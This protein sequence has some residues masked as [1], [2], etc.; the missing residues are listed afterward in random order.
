[1]E[2]MDWS[3]LRHFLAVARAG[4]TNKAARELGVNHTTC[5]RRIAALESAL[6]LPLFEHGRDGYRLTERGSELLPYAERVEAEVRAFCDAA[7]AGARRI[8]GTIRVTTNSS[9]ADAILVP[10]VRDL[11]RTVPDVRIDIMIADRRLDIA[12]GEADV[13]L[14]AGPPPTDPCLIARNLGR[15]AWGVFAS[16]DYLARN[17]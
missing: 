11:R 14:R 13:G 9:F 6:G 3:D 7:S 12:C 17:S 16:P 8:A 2:S 1:M 10:A 15:A 4:A 5:A